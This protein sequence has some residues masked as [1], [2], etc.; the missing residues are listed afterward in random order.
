MCR[1]NGPPLYLETNA[2]NAAG[3][4]QER[5]LTAGELDVVAGGMMNNPRVSQTPMQPGT[6]TGS[7][8]PDVWA[9]VGAG[10]AFLGW[11]VTVLALL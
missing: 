4:T 8:D 10:T 3:N 1:R 2:M 5:E 6:T 11:G 9:A 7:A